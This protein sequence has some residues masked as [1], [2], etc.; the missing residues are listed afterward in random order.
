MT[1][2]LKVQVSKKRKKKSKF[3]NKYHLQYHPFL[4]SVI[5]MVGNIFIIFADMMKLKLLKTESLDYAIL[6]R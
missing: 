1:N 4:L 5:L 3:S 2:H 6:E